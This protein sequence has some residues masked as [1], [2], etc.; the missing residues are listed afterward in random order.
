MQT[1]RQLKSECEG[2]LRRQEL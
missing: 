2:L 1:V